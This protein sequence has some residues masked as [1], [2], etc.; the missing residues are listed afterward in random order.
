MGPTQE[1]AHRVTQ[2]SR[3]WRPGQSQRD[4]PALEKRGEQNLTC[5]LKSS[6]GGE[7]PCCKQRHGFQRAV[8][9]EEASGKESVW[10]EVMAHVWKRKKGVCK[11][12]EVGCRA[13]KLLLLQQMAQTV[14]ENN[15]KLLSDRCG[16]QKSANGSSGPKIKVW[17]G[18]CSFGRGCRGG[19]RMAQQTWRW[20]WFNLPLSPA[21]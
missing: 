12:A 14:A 6:G 16:G 17:A 13:C 5:M 20:P 19:C 10:G 1:K 9:L 11:A 4:T 15:N 3:P 18:P 2:A 21:L 8:G 7:D